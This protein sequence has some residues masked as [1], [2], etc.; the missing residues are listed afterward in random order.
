MDT[1]MRDDVTRRGTLVGAM[2][3]VKLQRSIRN[4]TLVLM[5]F[6]L[7]TTVATVVAWV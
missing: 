6:A 3:D 1:R 4:M 2:E 5:A 7:I